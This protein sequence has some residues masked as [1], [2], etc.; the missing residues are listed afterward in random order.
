MRGI[1]SAAGYVPHHR[2]DRS[3]IAAFFGAGG[4]KGT[5]SVASYDED[6]TTLAVEAGRLA[7]RDAGAT[8]APRSV[9]FATST[10]T[11]VDKTNATIIHAALRL[12]RD[13]GAFDLGGGVRS[14][15][16]VLRNALLG[17]DA[18][19]L[20]T[21]ADIR[22]ANPT[23]PDEASSGDAGAA[24]LVGDDSAGP[25]IAEL[26]GAAS[27][28][29]EF[30]DTWRSPGEAETHHWE[31]RFA[32]TQ[33]EPLAAD[34]W[35]EA[36]KDAG[37]TATDVTTLV[38]TGAHARS[39][40][41]VTKS[42]GAGVGAVAPDLATTVGHVGTA[43][44]A[45]RLTAALEA[46]GPDEV[47]A[48]VGLADGVDVLILRTTEAIA[49]WH[50]SRTV[51]DQAAERP[52]NL[53][54]AKFLSWR[55]AVTV[56]PPNRPLPA[57]MS[58]SA[59]GRSVDWKYGFVGSKDRASGAVHLPPARVSYDGGNVDDSDPI[60][61]ADTQG[62]VATFTVDRL[63]YSPSPPVIFAV[64][65]FDGGGRLPVELTDTTPD[66]IEIG[67]QVEMTFR[68]LNA[69]DGIANYFWKA[70]PVR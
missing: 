40:K 26:L 25:V 44:A 70:R 1:I 38:V 21:A 2:L 20:V 17:G 3:E 50:P 4:G 53:A 7:L 19:T 60:P 36:L 24:I 37:V 43:D 49:D 56:Q 6:T 18:A 31:E 5:R 64:V 46:A 16:G 29:R 52:G 58:A 57:R 34:A 11:Y 22:V 66:E 67:A 28:T 47:I 41:S 42:L 54:Y 59:A 8:A 63:A 30:L 61:M 55:G 48:L 62:T 15:I 9:W 45:L 39:V 23:S 12:D 27:A 14:G 65:D 10:P 13:A 68:R 69:A 35:T 33:F 32:Q 51:N